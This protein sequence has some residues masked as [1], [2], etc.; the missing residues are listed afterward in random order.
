MDGLNLYNYLK[1]NPFKY[2]DSE[3]EIAIVLIPVAKVVVDIIALAVIAVTVKWEGDTIV[4]KI[5][6]TQTKTE[7][8][9]KE[10]DRKE[11]KIKKAQEKI[12]EWLGDD[13]EVITNSSGDK[14]FISEDGKRK[15]RFD[16]ERPYPHENPH[17]HVE[18][19]INDSWNDLGRQIYPVDLPQK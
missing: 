3:G 4:H 2:F 18:E 14:I 12:E 7:P 11:N 1:N 16:I 9:E 5:N 19:L 17:S 8:K 13:I 15:I 6:E 10:R